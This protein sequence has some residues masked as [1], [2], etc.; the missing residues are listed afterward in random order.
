[1]IRLF[2]DNLRTRWDEW[3]IHRAE[4]RGDLTC[5]LVVRLQDSQSRKNGAVMAKRSQ[6][7]IA[8]DKIDAEIRQLQ[9]VRERLIDAV[10]PPKPRAARKPKPRESKPDSGL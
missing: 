1:M 4:Q 6:I 9:L 2:L 5:D 3:R 8:L 7:Q 10:E